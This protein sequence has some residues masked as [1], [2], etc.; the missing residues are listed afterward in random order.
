MDNP[1]RP[2]RDVTDPATPDDM[3]LIPP[4]FSPDQMP[5]VARLAD[6]TYLWQALMGPL[7]FTRRS[8]WLIVLDP[9]GRQLG[10]TRIEDVRRPRRHR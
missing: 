9:A 4:L 2:G 3:T 5:P 8:L 1:H 6:L 7:G 10:L